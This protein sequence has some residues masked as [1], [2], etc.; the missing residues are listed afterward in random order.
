MVLNV[1]ATEREAGLL[2]VLENPDNARSTEKSLAV[3]SSKGN[4]SN[5]ALLN[6][7]GIMYFCILF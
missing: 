7:Q 6:L 1:K 5:D 2:K 3:N 4:E